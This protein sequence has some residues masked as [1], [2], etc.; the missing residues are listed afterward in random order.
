MLKLTAE[1][2]KTSESSWL[3]FSYIKNP[4]H[5]ATK[6]TLVLDVE[7]PGLEFLMDYLI[8]FKS[9]YI[10]NLFLASTTAF[11]LNP[12]NLRAT[13]LNTKNKCLKLVVKN[14]KEISVSLELD[15][16]TSKPL[17]FR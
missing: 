14:L 8:T 9:N 6:V 16:K 10:S 13:E 2:F 7:T 15:V 3:R 11:D 17:F 4:Q 5:E 12:R 1:H